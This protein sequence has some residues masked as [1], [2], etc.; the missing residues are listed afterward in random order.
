LGPLVT[1]AAPGYDHISSAIGGA[2]AGKAGADFLCYVTPSEYLG[3][4]SG[5]D[6]REGVIAVR[7]AA[8]AADLA[9]GNKKALERNL[10]ISQARKNST[11][12]DKSSWPSI[13]QR[14][15]VTGKS[16]SRAYQMFVPCVESSVPSNG[17]RNFF[18]IPGEC[19]S[20]SSDSMP[21]N[22][23][24]K[25]LHENCY[26]CGPNNGAGSGSILMK[27]MMVPWRAISPP[28]R[29]SRAI[30]V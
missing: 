19:F 29:D 9:R 6:V 12:K 1:D 26:A 30:R 25:N 21:L 13:R 22:Q 8:H 10:A 28:I 17:S 4:P 14:P 23:K 24:E 15:G 3:L 20:M 2:I 18:K 11:G 7:I 27:K 16:E 5:E